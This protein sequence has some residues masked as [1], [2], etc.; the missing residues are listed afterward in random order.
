[1]SLKNETIKAEINSIN[2]LSQNT[3]EAVKG[4]NL[5]GKK[6]I[7]ERLKILYNSHRSDPAG[8]ARV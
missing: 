4:E 7:E 5:S 3:I 1:M 6:W 2:I 8:P